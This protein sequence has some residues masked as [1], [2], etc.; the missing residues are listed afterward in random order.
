M[1]I[2]APIPKLKN[3]FSLTDGIFTRLKDVEDIPWG[4]DADL[5]SQLDLIYIG[6]HS[7]NKYVSPLLAIDEDDLTTQYKDDVVTASFAM[8]KNKWTRLWALNETEYNPLEN[9]SMEEKHTG[10]D[11]KLDTPT[12]WKDTETKTPTN[13]KETNEHKPGQSG[14]SETETQTPTDWKRTTESLKA[15]NESET[16]TSVYAMNSTDPVPSSKTK[17]DL[18]NKSEEEQTGT[19]ATEKVVE[20]VLIDEKSTTG[21]FKTETEKT[22]TYESKTTYNSTLKRSGNVGVTTSQQMAQSE[23]ELWKWLYFEEVFKDLDKILTLDTY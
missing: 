2:P 12:N 3:V 15:D 21:T 13:W 11:T 6:N 14:Y 4:D 20:G 18:K 23:I 19:F 10:N 9:Y 8:Y 1:W 22:G 5:A 17:T 7:G 16:S